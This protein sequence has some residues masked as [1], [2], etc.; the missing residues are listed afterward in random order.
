MLYVCVGR[1]VDG[2]PPES[3]LG[4][5]PSPAASSRDH[6]RPVC[7]GQGAPH[8]VLPVNGVQADPYHLL[9][10]RGQRG[11]VCTGRHPLSCI[12][13]YVAIDGGGNVSE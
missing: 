7:N 13:E 1:W 11:A 2:C 6:L 9:P 3:L 12:N 5:G 4:D 8:T 10:R